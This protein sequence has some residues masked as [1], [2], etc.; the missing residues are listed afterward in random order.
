MPSTDE[1]STSL[2]LDSEVYLSSGDQPRLKGKYSV[3]DEISDKLGS[4]VL[5]DKSGS[6]EEERNPALRH[7]YHAPP[8]HNE[9]RKRINQGI[10]SSRY[11]SS[12]S[13]L[14]SHDSFLLRIYFVFPAEL[15]TLNGQKY[16]NS[17]NCNSYNKILQRLWMIYKNAPLCFP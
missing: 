6:S 10:V 12:S 5:R 1:D 8:T 4:L 2:D 9:I 7:S 14:S 3:D 15:C 11:C 13:Y 17:P 16:L